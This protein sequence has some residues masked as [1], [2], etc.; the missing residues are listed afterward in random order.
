MKNI[1]KIY[2]IGLLLCIFFAG[3]LIQTQNVSNATSEAIDSTK[4]QN[5]TPQS[6]DFN[7][8]Y[9]LGGA[10]TMTINAQDTGIT[11]LI[12]DNGTD[13]KNVNSIFTEGTDSINNGTAETTVGSEINIKTLGDNETL[14]TDN[15]N[16]FN[17]SVDNDFNPHGVDLEANNSVDDT[18]NKVT[19]SAQASEDETQVDSWEWG[20]D[21]FFDVFYQVDPAYFTEAPAQGLDIFDYNSGRFMRAARSES[22]DL[23]WLLI[24]P[25]S[26]EYRFHNSDEQIFW[27]NLT[28]GTWQPIGSVGNCDFTSPGG[29][30]SVISDNQTIIV[31]DGNGDFEVVMTHDIVN[32]VAGY[33]ISI[34]SLTS[35]FSLIWTLFAN[36]I[37]IYWGLW[38]YT[39]YLMIINELLYVIIYYDYDWKIEY[40]LTYIV[41][42]WWS[43][44]I[45]IWFLD[46][47]IYWLI[48]F[49]WEWWI[50]TIEW[51]FVFVEYWYFVDYYV[52][53]EYRYTIYHWYYYYYV[54]TLYIPNMMHLSIT[55]QIFTNTT[56]LFVIEIHDY[57]GKPLAGA[58]LGGTWN[59]I[60]LTAENWTDNG[61]GTYD[62][63]VTAVLVAKGDPGIPLTLTASLMGYADGALNADIAVDPYTVNSKA[64]GDGTVDEPEEEEDTSTEDGDGEDEIS[65]PGPSFLL[66]GL[67]SIVPMLCIL[68]S[69]AKRRKLLIN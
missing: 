16:K 64:D 30:S 68:I 28:L 46:T 50:I 52:S 60:G 66:I 22:L 33:H 7:Q 17:A 45:E 40:Y 65:V 55:D 18:D 11:D 54:P 23:V 61:D 36:S 67:L 58:N 19:A 14:L 21:S 29:A 31:A 32:A 6:S 44:V 43:I 39:F 37:N 51:W 20:V 57:L 10:N 13:Q 5:E 2:S 59:S 27:F 47:Y 24:G 69:L 8:N 35:S 12:M 56:F 38:I 3:T 4:K 53:I 15:K 41:I 1:T 48:H 25:A 26:D 34:F 63:N 49:I 9:N 42:V 62:I